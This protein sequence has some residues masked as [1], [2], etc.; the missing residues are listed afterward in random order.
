MTT[1]LFSCSTWSTS[2]IS[3]ACMSTT[4]PTAWDG[5]PMSPRSWWRCSSTPTALANDPLDES[6]VAV[7]K[8][9]L[10]GC[11]RP[12]R[13]PTTPPSPFVKSHQRALSALFCQVLVLC[14]EAGLVKAGG[15]GPRRHQD[16]RQRLGTGEPDPWRSRGGGKPDPCRGHR[17]RR[18]RRRPPW[19]PQGRRAAC[20]VLVGKTPP[21]L[22][23]AD[24]VALLCQAQG[25]NAPAEAG[26]DHDHVVLQ[27]GVN[28]PVPDLAL[29]GLTIRST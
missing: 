3:R 26:A 19:G 9:S 7:S 5:R 20:E 22:H 12:T 16:R 2:S 13:F 17:H 6:S 28:E 15:P 14:Q 10:S 24:A 8:T 23:D 27:G 4:A 25:R 11:C 18:R 21:G 1:W 29:R